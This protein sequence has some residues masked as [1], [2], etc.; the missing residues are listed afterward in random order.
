MK[1]YEGNNKGFAL[2]S[3]VY[4]VNLTWGLELDKKIF[5][6]SFKG[7]YR[8]FT[9]TKSDNLKIKIMKSKN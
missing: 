8:E 4:T 9:K 2:K 1:H 3:I 7:F 5:E 6:V